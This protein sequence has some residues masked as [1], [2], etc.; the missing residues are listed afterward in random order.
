MKINKLDVSNYQSYCKKYQMNP[1]CAKVLAS[2]QLSDAQIEELLFSNM[3]VQDFDLSFMDTVVKRLITAKEQKEKVIVCGDYDC[4]GICATTIM[5]DALRKFGIDCGYYIPNRF[6]EGYGLNVNTV[7]LAK[8]KGYQ[9]LITVDNGVKAI[10]ALTL[11]KEKGID[12]ILSDHHEYDEQELICDYFLHPKVFPEYFQGLCGAGVAYLLSRRLIGNDDKHTMLACVATIG[13]IVPLVK[14]NR[15]LVKEG[16]ALLNNRSYMALQ[17][18]QNDTKYWDSKKI[19]FQI[20]PKINCVGRMADQANANM[21][22]QYLLLEND[23][24]IQRMLVQINALNNTRKELSALMENTAQR[25]LLDEPF[26][27]LYDE[28]FHEGLNGI[29]ASK[30]MNQTM[31]PV[32]VLSKQE[33]VLKG[34]IRSCSVDLRTFFDDCKEHL[35]AYG[36]HKE[37]AGISFDIS[38]LATIQSHIQKKMENET[39]EPEVACIMLDKKEIN[40]QDIASLSSL[41]PFGCGFTLPNFCIEDQNLKIQSLS[42]GKHIKYVGEQMSY[43]FFNQG[44]RIELDKDRETFTF[45][46]QLEANNFWGKKSINMIVDFID[47]SIYNR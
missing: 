23:Q 14:A 22:V 18:L 8:E 9:I 41:E 46:G 27:I 15:I 20:V 25:L 26:I 2:K 32:M 19:A 35:L 33:N 16:I 31:K 40:Y 47:D 30:I 45:I 13:D 1:L 21:M 44:K 24:Q 12:I 37:A 38:A 11:A 6:S 42:N 4:D 3:R 43:L 10:E 28:S 39:Y 17:L 34:S 36:G 29:V 5:V 7:Q